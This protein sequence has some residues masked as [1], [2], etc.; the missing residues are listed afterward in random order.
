MFVYIGMLPHK[1]DPKDQTE[2]QNR[3]MNTLTRNFR[4]DIKDYLKDYSFAENF[5][6]SLQHLRGDIIGGVTSAIVALPL[7][8]GFGILAFNGDPRG[9]VAGLYGAI[10]TGILAALFGG[11]SQQITGPTGG[12]T[13]ILTTVYMQHGGAE[14]LLAACVVAGVFQI[15]YGLLKI[16]KYV[17][18]VPYP[19]TVGFTNGIAILIFMQ[20][21]KTFGTAPVIAF[22]TMATIYLSSR[23]NKNL[24]KSL[25]G[26]VAGTLAAYFFGST[27]FFRMTT[28]NGESGMFS[29]ASAIQVIGNI[30]SSFQAPR[31]PAISWETWKSVLPAGFT[32]SLLGAIE[33]LLTSVVADNAANTRHNS[34]K[35]LIGQGIGNFAAPFFGGVAGTGAIVRTMVNIRAGAKTRLSGI[36]HGLVLVFVMLL[37]NDFAAAIPLAALAGVLMMTAVGML[38]LEP[39]KL[40]PRTPAAD[41]AVMLATTLITVFT[42]LITAVEVG[43]VMAAFLFIHRMSELG[44]DQKLLEEVKGVSLGEETLKLLRDNKIVVFDIEGPL[45]FGAAKG[46]VNALEKNFDVKVVILDMENVPIVDTTGAVVLEDIVERLHQDKKRLLIVGMRNKVRKVLY[47]LGVTQRIGIGNFMNTIDEAIEYALALTKDNIEHT[48]L[49]SYVSEKLIMLNV[50]SGHRDELFQ[51]MAVQASKAGVV[52]NKLEF[53]MNIVEREE[54]APTIIGKGVA[55]PHARSGGSNSKVVVIFARL[56][57]P[58]A[59]GTEASE[60]VHTVFMVATGGNEKEYLEVLRLIALNVNNDRVFGRLLAASDVHEVHHILTEVK[61]LSSRSK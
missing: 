35:E 8:L 50:Q 30:P 49:A 43:M 38:E 40:L 2:K 28:G 37:L 58:I 39:I 4:I 3:L 42:D 60:K 44:M 6:F 33:T 10:F 25:I 55:V 45:F 31:F 17:H 19:V 54:E 36:I 48:H 18:M 11:T 7:A 26:L 59:Y 15:G 27:E 1:F 24:P 23:L 20:Q 52:R 14:A 29:I 56:K 9:A 57:E 16:G 12:M 53:L 22:I 41:A 61:N 46:F 47:D 13:V 34:N 32:I 5:R 51:K 21:F